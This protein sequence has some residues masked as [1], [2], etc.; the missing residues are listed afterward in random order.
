MASQLV[1]RH[2][3]ITSSDVANVSAN[4]AQQ[5][6]TNLFYYETEYCPEHWGK[7]LNSANPQGV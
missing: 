5:S 6:E 3:Y 1:E 2:K 4:W 7:N